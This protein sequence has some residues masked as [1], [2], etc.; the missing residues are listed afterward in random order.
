MRTKVWDPP[1]IELLGGQR[2]PKMSPKRTH[3]LVQAAMIAILRRCSAGSGQVVPEWRC[4]FSA[5]DQFVPDVGYMS[6]DRLLPLSESEREEPP[7]APD[8][9][10]EV[11]SPSNRAS[12]DAKKIA[13]Y[14][15]HGAQM[16][17]DIDPAA[18]TVHAHATGAEARTFRAMDTFEHPHAPWLHFDIAELFADIDLPRSPSN[19]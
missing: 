6:F 16:V 17:L 12:Y 3:G 7:Y 2:H 8:I 1:E 18:R 19:G 9:A 5:Q 13:V 4:R 14:L 10:V 11:R 15:A